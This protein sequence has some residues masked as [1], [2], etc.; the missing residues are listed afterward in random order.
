MI[1]SRRPFDA[2]PFLEAFAELCRASR[3]Y[4]GHGWGVAW[5]REGRW[6]RYRT[7][8]PV[9]E[10]DC[11]GFGKCDLLAAHAR[12]AFRDRG[13]AV[14]YNMPFFREGLCFLFNGELHG[15]RV[16][17]RGGN[18]AEKLFDFILRCRRGSPAGALARAAELLPR[19]A[20][21]VRALNVLMTDGR[22]LYL[23]SRFDE[24]PDYFTLHRREDRW[25]TAVCS[26]P[27]GPGW[28]A[29]PNGTVAV[30]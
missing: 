14:R 26:G 27:L 19:R 15:V 12:S 17:A 8:L 11:S 6:R 24:D 4:Q 13:I 18:G 23:A 5:R 22:R 3:E 1:R 9:W 7:L 16:R 20:A 28:K 21:R 25:F 2:R 29:V 30:L 10:D